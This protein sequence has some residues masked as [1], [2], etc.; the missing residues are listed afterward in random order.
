MHF[1]FIKRKARKEE[2]LY[3]KFLFSVSNSISNKIQLF[4]YLSCEKKD[5]IENE[6]A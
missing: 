4:F 3:E 6:I 5:Y 1:L 2:M